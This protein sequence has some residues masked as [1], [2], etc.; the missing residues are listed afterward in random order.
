[1]LN[2]CA[3]CQ[4]FLGESPP[5]QNF[6]VTHRVCPGCQ[7]KAL[8]FTEPEFKLAESLRDI[9]H[10]LYH[11]GRIGDLQAG[12]RIIELAVAAGIRP[13]DILMGIVAPA[14]FQVGEEWR[15]GILSVSAEHRF[16]AYCNEV[17]GRIASRTRLDLPVGMA[18]ESE[19]EV[20]LM[21]A[22]GNTHT[23]AIRILTL[24][25]QSRGM[26]A[27]VIDMPPAVEELVTLVGRSRP[28][29]LLVSLALAE[30]SQNVAAIAARIAELP[31]PVR[32]TLIVGGY[33]VK[34]GLVSEIRGARLMAD[35]SSL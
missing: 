16:T 28:R 13:V 24:W 9:Q 32:P 29:L 34:L 35:I 15:Q 26:R 17:F 3:Y 7:G 14:L 19:P 4:Q 10:Q 25:L 27:S 1:M 11:A 5:Y 8:A 12:E 22:P 23:L 31:P 2:W 21:N 20:M 30:Q 33:A 18:A 6:V